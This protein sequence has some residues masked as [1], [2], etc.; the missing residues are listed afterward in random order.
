MENNDILDRWMEYV[1]ELDDDEKGVK[2]EPEAAKQNI[3]IRST[4]QVY[5]KK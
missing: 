5:Q 2:P 3:R 1:S 4:I